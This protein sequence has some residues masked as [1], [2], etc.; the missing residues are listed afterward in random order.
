MNL[1]SLPFVE[2][3]NLAY[4]LNGNTEKRGNNHFHIQ[5]EHYTILS[6]TLTAATLWMLDVGHNSLEHYRLYREPERAGISF[7]TKTL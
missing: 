7:L 6:T 3:F 5:Q 1:V 4:E 2:R